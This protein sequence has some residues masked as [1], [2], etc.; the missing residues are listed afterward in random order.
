M[1]QAPTVESVRAVSRLRWTGVKE[2]ALTENEILLLVKK[3]DAQ[4]YEGIVQKY[5]QTAYY[6]ALSFVHNPQDALDLSQESFIKAFRKIKSFDTD[7]AFFPWFYRI[8]KNLC[9]DHFKRIRYRREIPLEDV[10]V[11]SQAKEDREMKEALWK[12]IEAL[13]FEQRE[14]I[15]LRYFR[16]YSYQEIAEITRKPLGTVMSSLHYAKKKLKKVVGKYL[17]FDEGKT[18]GS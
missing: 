17:G 6:I 16:D 5:M 1:A 3:G 4:A 14:V 8:L 18:H 2:H 15:I 10:Q 11:L 9:I 12:G 13:S 7:R